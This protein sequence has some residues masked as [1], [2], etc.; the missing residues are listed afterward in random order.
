MRYA[1]LLVAAI[2]PLGELAA[3]ESKSSS[4]Q[5][6]EAHVTTPEHLNWGPAPAILPAGARLAVLE[7]DPSKAGPF[8]M[9]LAMPA[10]Y[11]IPPHFHQVDEHVTVIS[12]AF[13]VGMGETFDESKLTTLSP[14]TFGV[15]PPGMRHFARA[16]KPTVIQLHGVGPWGLTYV[17][18]ADQ[19]N[20]PSR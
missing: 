11:R 10:G 13:Q 17:N 12:G 14:G 20:T 15:I 1:L 2:L 7:G 8:T 16:D 18:R 4:A 19:P 5:P 6:R 9:R 3:Q